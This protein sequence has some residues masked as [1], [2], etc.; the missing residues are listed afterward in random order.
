MAS[1]MA[2]PSKSREVEMTRALITGVTGQDG[3]HL[4]EFLAGRGD[5]VYGLL[6]G[7]SN[8][9]AALVQ[10]EVPELNCWGE[11]CRTCRPSSP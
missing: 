2:S 1:L 4:A 5:E 10:E 7:Q 6:R 3:R 11:T 8:P 9:K